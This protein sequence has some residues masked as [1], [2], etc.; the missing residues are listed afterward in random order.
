MIITLKRIESTDHGIF[1]HLDIEGFSCVTLENHLLNIPVGSYKVTLFHSPTHGLVPLLHDVPNR[2]AIEIHEGNWE[3]NSKG[4]IL[5]AK[6]RNGFAIEHSKETLKALV[7]K[8]K[9]ADDVMLR[10]S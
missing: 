9:D 1:G 8:I 3:S 7:E 2:S 6:N 4:C 10:I 5:V